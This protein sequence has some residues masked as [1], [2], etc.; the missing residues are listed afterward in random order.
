MKEIA[1]VAA[2]AA[3]AWAPAFAQEMPRPADGMKKF[4][5]MIGDW[6]GSGTM[7]M[8]P[9]DSATQWTAVSSVK[10]ILD[11]H[12]IQEDLRIDMGTEAPYVMVTIYGWDRELDQPTANTVSN[13]GA[14]GAG[15]VHWLDSKTLVYVGHGLS[16]G[17]PQAAR[18]IATYGKDSYTFQMDEASGSGPFFT[19]AQGKFQRS[20]KTFSART[21]EASVALMPPDPKMK[22]L[23]PLLGDYRFEGTVLMAPG[24]PEMDVTGKETIASI[25]GGTSVLAH[26]VGDEAGGFV[27]EAFGFIYW[28]SVEQCFESF[29]AN[30]MG[31][32]H[33]SRG[34]WQ[35]NDRLVF[36][37]AHIQDGVPVSQR[38]TMELKDGKLARVVADRFHGAEKA[39]KY[40]DAKY[41]V[42]GAKGAAAAPASLQFKEG[43][44]CARAKA[45]GTQCAH[46]CC[47]TATK[48]GEV[49][50][51]C[52]G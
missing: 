23:D 51:G 5:P 2:A 28:N 14:G 22:S 11:G 10:S 31:E 52:N 19:H 12:F 16:Q 13:A 49:C 1:I 43:S 32:L 33:A 17:T 24:M 30:N 15:E 42:A 38:M 37:D 9:E 21:Q 3:L 27:Y 8:A 36:T 26:V 35:G 47:V 48:A 46:P 41:W 7:R 34:R 6:E 44:C 45:A 4:A 25:L 18:W 40:F 50:V 29:G 39:A 20:S